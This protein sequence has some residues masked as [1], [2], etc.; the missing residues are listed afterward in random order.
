[1]PKIPEVDGIGTLGTHSIPRSF[2]RHNAS[3]RLVLYQARREKRVSHT[4]RSPK[5]HVSRKGA[6][7][8]KGTTIAGVLR[9]LAEAIQAFLGELSGFA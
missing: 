7:D 1:M 3:G 2:N 4:E 5:N 9:P 6:K 8:A